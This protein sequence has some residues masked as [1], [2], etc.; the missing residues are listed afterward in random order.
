MDA[1]IDLRSDTVTKPSAAM[2]QAMASAEVGDDWYGD[3][4][5]VN[6]LQDRA[7]GLA[8][9]AGLIAQATAAP[10][11]AAVIDPDDP[12]FAAPGDMP[13]RA[14]SAPRTTA[15]KSASLPTHVNTKMAP[16]AA[17]RGVGADAPPLSRTQFSA[18]AAVRL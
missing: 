4:P 17:S 15:R 5:T 6:A 11:F 9:H 14:P 2:R 1:R 18:R 12:G 8:E 10:P 7:A 3:D 13:A 16:L